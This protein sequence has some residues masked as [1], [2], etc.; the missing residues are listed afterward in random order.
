MP[1]AI[2]QDMIQTVAPECPN[3]ALNIGILPG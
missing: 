3:Q 2:D 1:V